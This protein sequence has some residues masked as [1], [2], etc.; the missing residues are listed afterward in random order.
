MLSSGKKPQNRNATRGSDAQRKEQVI[1][2]M[3]DEELS[4]EDGGGHEGD[5]RQGLRKVDDVTRRPT[6]VNTTVNASQQY[7]IS[8][9]SSA[10]K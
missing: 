5:R 9:V 7:K 1:G 6:G 10:Q 8:A 2:L 3:S 4:S